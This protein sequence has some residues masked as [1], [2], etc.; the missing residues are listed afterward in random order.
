MGGQSG[1]FPGDR[2]SWCRTRIAVTSYIGP[3]RIG[4]LQGRDILE[5]R[6]Q[7]LSEKCSDGIG[8]DAASEATMLLVELDSL[9]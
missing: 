4:G 2:R 9:P 1:E 8:R 5:R 7:Q 3:H 6:L